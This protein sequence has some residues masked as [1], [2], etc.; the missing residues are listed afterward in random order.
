M[1]SVLILFY[2]TQ[3]VDGRSCSWFAVH[4]PYISPRETKIHISGPIPVCNCNFHLHQHNR[5]VLCQPRSQNKSLFKYC[6][7][8]NLMQCDVRHRTVSRQTIKRGCDGLVVKWIRQEEG[9]FSVSVFH[10]T[11]TNERIGEKKNFFLYE[12]N[13]LITQYIYNI[14]IDR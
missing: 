12:R 11:P 1:S 5:A 4:Y 2:W 7:T 14:D 10:E 3:S 6:N 8:S 13:K 9:E